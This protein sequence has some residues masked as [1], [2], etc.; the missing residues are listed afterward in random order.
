MNRIVDVWLFDL[1]RHERADGEIVVI[2][3]KNLPFAVARVFTVRAPAGAERGK[4]AHRLCSQMMSCVHG[5][6]DVVCDDGNTRRTYILD[7]S[8]KALLIPPMIWATISFRQTESV[9]TVLCDRPYE[10][11]DYVR[12][13]SDFLAMRSVQS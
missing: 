3:G 9:L 13:Y 5:S 10:E 1:P 4:H 12:A 6:L 8:D 7:R 11:H 2:E